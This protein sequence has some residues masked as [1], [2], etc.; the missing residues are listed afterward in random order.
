MQ[1]TKH[2]VKPSTGTRISIVFFTVK[3]Y[4]TV[5]LESWSM[6][7]AL[8]FHLPKRPVQPLSQFLMHSDEQ[9]AKVLEQVT[10]DCTTPLEPVADRDTAR[11]TDTGDRMSPLT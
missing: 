5:G 8:G 11:E 4:E 9:Y 6:L 3:G 10:A 2:K 1:C 7:K